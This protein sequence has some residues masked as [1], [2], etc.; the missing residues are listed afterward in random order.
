MWDTGNF[1]TFI[2]HG[3]GE[4][5]EA[6]TDTQF[7]NVKESSPAP[8]HVR[9]PSISFMEGKS[10]DKRYFFYYF[11]WCSLSLNTSLAVYFGFH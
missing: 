1:G 9:K 5:D 7:S 2:V 8:G 4:M 3:G 10:A 6:A 11:L